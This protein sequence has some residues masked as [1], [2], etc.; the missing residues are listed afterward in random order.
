MENTETT[1]T[2]GTALQEH[3][4]RWEELV[5]RL[6]QDP[7][8]ALNE[9]FQRIAASP[10]PVVVGPWLSEVG[11]ELLY[12]VPFLNWA[13]EKFGIKKDRVIAVS[14]GGVESWYSTAAS[15]Y[16]EIFG[17]YSAED[18]RDKNL[19]RREV[20]KTQ[21]QTFVSD[22]DVEILR[23][24][25]KSREIDRFEWIHPL[26]MYLLF[27]PYWK[28]NR[29]LTWIA[30]HAR[31]RPIA[32]P[33]AGP[34][35]G[36]PQ[37]Y[38]AV[39][40]YFSKAFPKTAENRDFIARTLGSLTAAENVVLLNTGLSLDDHAELAPKA[41]KRLFSVDQA[42]KTENNLRVQSQVIG[43]AKAFYGTYGGFSYLAPFMNVPSTSFF[44]AENT[45]H[46][47][48]LEVAYRA[49]RILKYGSFDG[50]KLREGYV[51]Q[52]ADFLALHVRQLDPI[53]KMVNAKDGPAAAMAPDAPLWRRAARRVKKHALRAL[54]RRA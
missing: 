47:S 17:R 41:R 44:S 51:P 10:Y 30:S 19:Q 8:R 24:V 45:L 53:R 15:G 18:F 21:K 37:D 4:A 12:W 1:I 32:R 20:R 38:V 52:G 40:F 46:L 13:T 6:L 27:E 35:P 11:F 49:C 48:H 16:W 50:I 22:F 34:L 7:D 14:R 36:L 28:S 25:L 33:A 5:P 9:M 54:G 43:G 29:G 42:L 2:N 31:F 3:L 26:C 39:K 23:E